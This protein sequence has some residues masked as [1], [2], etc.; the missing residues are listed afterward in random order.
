MTIEN[1]LENKREELGKMQF[2]SL[3]FT[4][5]EINALTDIDGLCILKLKNEFP[6]DFVFSHTVMQSFSKFESGDSS[7]YRVLEIC[8]LKNPSLKLAVC[9]VFPQYKACYE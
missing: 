6:N 4:V 7:V 9:K 3:V 8:L 1:I 2:P 5:D